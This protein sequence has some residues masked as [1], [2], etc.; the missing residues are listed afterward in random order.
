MRSCDIDASAAA[1]AESLGNSA[2]RTVL[3]ILGD[4][5][6]ESLLLAKL[7][8][9]L[10]VGGFKRLM[11]ALAIENRFGVSAGGV[12]FICALATSEATSCPC[13]RDLLFLLVQACFLLGNG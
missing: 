5:S 9:Q 1:V 12:G 10:A 13:P 11:L 7:R 6:D 3:R 8:L 2:R 4:L